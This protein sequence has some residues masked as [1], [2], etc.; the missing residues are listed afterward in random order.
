[1]PDLRLCNRFGILLVLVTHF[2]WAEPADVEATW[3]SGDGDGWI[4]IRRVG[5]GLTAKLVG[6][7]NDRPD[8]PPRLDAK[9]PDSMLRQ[10]TLKGLEIFA[11]FRYAGGDRWTGGTI[12]DPNSGKTYRCT[13]TLVDRDVLEVRGYVGV[14]LFGRSEYWRRKKR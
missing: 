14:S 11:G 12:Y 8:D 1:M 13:V 7:P 2:V 3:L 10:R 4:E 6:S 9:N 5:D